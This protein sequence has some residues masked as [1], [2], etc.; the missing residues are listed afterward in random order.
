MQRAL[1]LPTIDGVGRSG[2]HAI[3]LAGGGSGAR[4]SA[5]QSEEGCWPEESYSFVTGA[6]PTGLSIRASFLLPFEDRRVRNHELGIVF[7]LAIRC[8][9]HDRVAKSLRVAPLRVLVA[10][11]RNENG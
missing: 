11:P 7:G 6:P 9:D 1:G 3:G 5:A 8:L 2:N 4:A 10:C